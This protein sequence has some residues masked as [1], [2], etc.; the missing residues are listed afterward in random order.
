V[1][2]RSADEGAGSDATFKVALG[3]ELGVGVEDGEAGDFQFRGE[4]A[5]GGD[6]LTGGEVATENC[7]AE[8]GV[9]LTVE[10]CGGLAV[11]G[12]DGDDSGR[13]VNH[14]RILVVM[15]NCWQ[16]VMGSYHLWRESGYGE[17]PVVGSQ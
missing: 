15:H 5:T 10:G 8:S 3:E 2:E 17:R 6:L 11:D 9:D 1:G 12:D 4:G 13:N 7:V 16:V 14:L